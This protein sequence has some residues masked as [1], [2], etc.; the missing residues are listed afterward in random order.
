MSMSEASST[1]SP[2]TLLDIDSVIS[3]RALA[4]GAEPSAS[5]VGQ[6]TDLCGLDRALV[7]R[8]ALRA[9]KLASKTSAT[10]GHNS[11]ASP[12]TNPDRRVK[13][14]SIGTRGRCGR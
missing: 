8:S 11:G 1:S 4:G 12:I 2:S 7:S 14:P 13:R 10:Y 6:M 5:L 3:L 9:A